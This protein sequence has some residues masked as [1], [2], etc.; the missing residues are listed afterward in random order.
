MVQLVLKSFDLGWFLRVCLISRGLRSA[1]GAMSWSN[2]RFLHWSA[3]FTLY[4][5]PH[6]RT[7]ASV[8]MFEKGVQIGEKWGRHILRNQMIQYKQWL[9]FIQC[10][11]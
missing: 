10:S 3:R 9:P 7:S 6:R 4:S 1:F 11:E 2:F 5:S 8:I